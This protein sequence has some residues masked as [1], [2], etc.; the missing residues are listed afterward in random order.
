MFDVPPS[1]EARGIEAYRL[2]WP[3]FFQ[4]QKGGAAFDIVSLKV[5]AGEDVAFATALLR[6]GTT[7]EL[8][9]D[10]QPRTSP[11]RATAHRL[12]VSAVARIGWN[13]SR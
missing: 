4:W 8:E 10:P 12:G 1:V 13:R 5:T 3:P 9:K 11:G 7:E 6:C 2:T